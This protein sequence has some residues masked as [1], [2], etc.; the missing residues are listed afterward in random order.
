MLADSAQVVHI[1]ISTVART[2]KI[3]FCGH[4]HRTAFAFT[5]NYEYYLVMVSQSAE[6]VAD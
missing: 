4:Q 1:R 6:A 5:W 2:K 3:Q